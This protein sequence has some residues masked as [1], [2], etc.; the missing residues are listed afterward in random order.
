MSK[1]RSVIRLL[2]TKGYRKVVIIPLLFFVGIFIYSLY[3]NYFGSPIEK[4]VLDD[5][6][7]RIYSQSDAGSCKLPEEVDFLNIP[8]NDK[9]KI[10]N[11]DIFLDKEGIVTSVEIYCKTDKNIDEILSWYSDKLNTLDMSNASWENYKMS[12]SYNE[13]SQLLELEL[14]KDIY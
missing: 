4:T 5:G 2:T 13:Y 10:R 8:I 3:V 11:Y 12:V 7:T 9:L 6:T 14:V 1:W